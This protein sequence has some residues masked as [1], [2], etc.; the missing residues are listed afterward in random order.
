MSYSGKVKRDIA[1]WVEAGLVD[2]ATGERLRADIGRNGSGQVSFG[3]VLAMMAAALFGAAVLILIASNWEERPRIGRVAMLFVIIAAGYIGGAVLQ[4]RDRSGFGEAAYVIA[5]TA[6]GATIALIGQMY[7]MSGDETQAILVWCAGTALAAAVLK[8]NALSVGAVLLA[9]AWMLMHTFDNWS[10]FDLPLSYLLLAAVLYALCFWTR[11]FAG[12]HLL[13][14]SLWLFGFLFYWNVESLVVPCVVILASCA[15][16]AAGKMMPEGAVRYA[17]LG[18]GVAVQSLIGFLSGVGVIQL[19]YADEGSFLLP[20]ILAFAG[21]VAA[22]LLEGRENTPLR[23]LS[24]AAFIFQLG[25]V[26]VVMLGTMLGTA[27]FFI[28]GGFIFAGLAWMITRFERRFSLP[29]EAAPAEGA[30][31]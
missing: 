19:A 26:Y 25:F 17:G 2:A 1:R 11:S 5:A 9:I 4:L 23:W 30:G 7:H 16:F 21:I 18:N 10:M 20:T 3:N 12:R 22:M 28:V 15:L 27:G 6:F 24:Y 8:S 13:L 29:D 31:A 14:A